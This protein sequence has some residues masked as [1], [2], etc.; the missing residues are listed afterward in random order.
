MRRTVDKC[1]ETSALDF[2]V[3]FLGEKVPK[4]DIKNVGTR[5][6]KKENVIIRAM[7]PNTVNK[8]ARNSEMHSAISVSKD[9][10]KFKKLS[11]LHSVAPFLHECCQ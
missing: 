7:W 2:E 4:H 8:I 5:N 9:E 10:I 3:G 6:L 11:F 1:V